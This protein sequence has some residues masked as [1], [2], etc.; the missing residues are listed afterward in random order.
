MTS[1][2]IIERGPNE[3]PLVT[4]I[5]D[6]PTLRIEWIG[7]VCAVFTDP[8]ESLGFHALKREAQELFTLPGA[9]RQL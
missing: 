7:R 6:Q 1:P 8:R 9:N 4:E 2:D 3:G 5:D